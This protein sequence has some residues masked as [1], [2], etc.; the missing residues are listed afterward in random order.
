MKKLVKRVE[1]YIAADGKEFL[2]LSDCLFY[3]KHTMKSVMRKTWIDK[4]YNDFIKNTLHFAELARKNGKFSGY[5]LDNMKDTFVHGDILIRQRKGRT[6]IIN[7]RTGK[8]G[9]SICSNPEYFDEITGFAVA[10]AR[11]KG[12]EVPDYI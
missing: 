8:C 6:T 3:E 12:E 1:I 5:L 4:H 10:W 11:Y 9:K 7:I 2:N